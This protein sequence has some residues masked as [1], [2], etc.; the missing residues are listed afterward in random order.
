M[1]LPALAEHGE[2]HFEGREFHHDGGGWRGDRHTVE[3]W[4]GGNWVHDRHDGRLGWWWV[5]AGMW[6]FYPDPVYPYPDPYTPPVVVVNPQPVGTRAASDRPGA[7]AVAI[8]V[9]LRFAK[10]L[11]PVCGQLPARRGA[12]YRRSHPCRP[13]LRSRRQ[14]LRTDRIARDEV[15]RAATECIFFVPITGT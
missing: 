3:V 11:L 1:S 13:S 4:R 2:R 7:A 12:R 15:V 14:L 9:L 6:Y 8:L 10:S 5:A